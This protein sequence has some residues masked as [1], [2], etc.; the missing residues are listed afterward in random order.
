[1]LNAWVSSN[2]I[3]QAQANSIL[4]LGATQISRAQQLGIT[5]GVIDVIAARSGN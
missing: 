2:A 4:A 1:M 5:V 3:T